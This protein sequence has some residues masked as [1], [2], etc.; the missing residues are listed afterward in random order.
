MITKEEAKTLR[1]KIKAISDAEDLANRFSC[2]WTNYT[3]EYVAQQMTDAK[4]GLKDYINEI[5]E[6]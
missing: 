3:S 5:T 6:K 1:K 4:K 2:G